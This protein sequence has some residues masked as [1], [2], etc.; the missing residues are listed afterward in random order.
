MAKSNALRVAEYRERQKASGLVSITL[1]I[2]ESEV[3]F[4]REMAQSAQRKKRVKPQH[5]PHD[6]AFAGRKMPATQLALAEHW[7]ASSGLKLQLDQPGLKLAQV[8]AKTIAHTIVRDGW[9]VGRVL[10]SESELQKLYGVGRNL[11]REAIRLLEHQGVVRIRPGSGGGLVVAV[12]NID[13][14]AYSVGLYLEFRRIK[15]ADLQ[16]TRQDIQR[17]ILERCLVCID[18]NGR[19]QLVELLQFERTLDRRTASAEELQQFHLLLAQLTGDP[20]LELLTHL[21][22]RLFRDHTRQHQARRHPEAFTRTLEAHE[23]IVEAILAGDNERARTQM[24]A[25]IEEINFWIE[26]V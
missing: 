8:L 5:L 6:A 11:L 9:Q 4:F 22:L 21:M 7:V 2:P 20:T 14:V 17:L 15:G 1:S 12:P 24:N 10:G 25:H 26:D 3:P 23:H 16:R 18:G 13:A 19:R